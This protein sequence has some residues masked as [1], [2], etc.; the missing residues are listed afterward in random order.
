MAGSSVVAVS[1][2]RGLRKSTR[3]A[4]S[5]YHH[6]QQ[7]QQHAVLPDRVRPHGGG[8]ALR[9]GLRRPVRV[10]LRD[11]HGVHPPDGALHAAQ[12]LADQGQ[13]GQDARVALQERGGGRVPPAGTVHRLARDVVPQQGGILQGVPVRGQRGAALVLHDLPELL[14]PEHRLHAQ[15]HQQPLQGQAQRQRRDAR[16]P[17][18]HHLAHALLVFVYLQ[19][20]TVANTFFGLFALVWFL[21]R[22]FF[23][24]YNILHS[25]YIYAYSDIIAPITEAGS[26]HGIDASV[27]YWT[28]I[29]WFGFLCVLL[30]LH[31]YWGLLIVKMVIK[32]LGDGNVEKDIRSDSEGEE[33]AAEEEDEEPKK[34]LEATSTD[35][36]AKPRRRRAPKAE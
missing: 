23:Y 22:W 30:V 7:Q 34:L 5:R 12:E 4:Q 17:L 18:C 11:G 14:V 19:W 25:V 3:R 35:S 16:A 33:D 6:Q 21:V 36:A 24:S 32:A 9:H 8:Q 27:W 29:V 2:C 31:V 28:W 20:E 13:A 10:P 1:C 15:H 26:F